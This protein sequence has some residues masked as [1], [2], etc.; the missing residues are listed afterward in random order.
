M[1]GKPWWILLVCGLSWSCG[2]PVEMVGRSPV[3]SIYL[4]PRPKPQQKQKRPVLPSHLVLEK[5]AFIEPSGNRALDAGE[6][7]SLRITVGNNGLGPAE[8]AVRLMPLGSVEHLDF[9][10]HHEVGHVLPGQ[11]REI[12][13]PLSA[14]VGVVDGQREMR[15]EIVD[16]F[17]RRSLPFTLRFA[18]RGLRPAEIR[19]VVRDYDDGDF[20]K[21]NRPDGRV[22]AGE[23]VRVT[24]NV[25]NLGGDLPS[26]VAVVEVQGGGE[27]SFAR[28]LE[29]HADNRFPLG[30]MAT[31]QNRDVEF[32]FY[33]SPLFDQSTV[34]FHLTL[35][36]EGRFDAEEV[37]SFDVGQSVE[38]E[39]VLAVEA[40]QEK[41]QS[42]GPMELVESAGIDVE[43]IPPNSKT[44]REQGL[45]IIFGIEQYKY[46]PV[47]TWKYRD[48]ATFY[49]YS[50]DVLGIPE[51]RI[52]LR[53][54]E[55][56]TKAEF[57]Y[58][59]EAKNTKND[60][61][62]KKRLRDPK[63]AAAA[64]VFVYLAGHGFPDLATGQ[65]YLIPYDVRPEQATNGISLERLYRTLNEFGARSVT[66]FVESCFSGT[67]G[68]DRGPE[69]KLLAMDMNPVVPVMKR[70]LIGPQM[71]VFTATSGE[72]PSSNR[73]D[74]KH[75]IFTYFVLKGLGGAADG[76]G[77]GGVS[78]EE[79]FT[80][81]ERQVPAKAL[82]APLDREQVPE[83]WPSV[84]RL[85]ERGKRI[86]V[87]Y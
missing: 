74:L 9:L 4:S 52:M 71:V 7:G 63:T 8:V 24:A 69:P 65:P 44:R 23:M 57:D 14:G 75:G 13:I 53:T 11:S 40:V 58:I 1:C 72:K 38:T 59:F 66:I 31:G 5:K 60:G 68:Y 51:E 17:S 29:G 48:A 25:Q 20:F 12:E 86:L 42:T 43:Q 83:V 16:E 47:A 27:V 70:P 28:D 50:R 32:Y 49:R 33:T 2:G 54:D 6:E 30:R 37:L 34:S 35:E 62:L 39:A 36:A 84:D 87:Q 15:V 73:N 78:V 80:Y 3:G 41:R 18:T 76:N 64:D 26:A 81:L 61:W 45:A 77:D 19:V 46:A 85:G 22:E 21:G 82:E 55:D 10:R 67:S 56:A 79:L